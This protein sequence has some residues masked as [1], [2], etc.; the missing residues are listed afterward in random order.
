MGPMLYGGIYII[1]DILDKQNDSKNPAKCKRPIASGKV[2]VKLSI[3]I[4]VCLITVGIILA[5]ILSRKFFVISGLILLNN[6]F[7]SIYPRIKNIP[8]LNMGSNSLNYGLRYLGGAFLAGISNASFFCSLVIFVFMFLNFI[9][10]R[11]KEYL[12]EGVGARIIFK[13]FS[14]D[15]LRM[16]FNVV[17]VIFVIVNLFLY[18]EY[19]PPFSIFI[20]YMGFSFIFMRIKFYLSNKGIPFDHMVNPVWT[21]KFNKSYIFVSL[22]YY[23]EFFLMLMYFWSI[24]K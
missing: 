13:Q 24:H 19:R 3:V 10:F 2:T 12:V 7:Y 20:S 17:Q 4:C 21:Y 5:F 18:I 22:F 23:F 6:F 15:V 1:N 9:S 16:L 8:Y 11:I 14:K